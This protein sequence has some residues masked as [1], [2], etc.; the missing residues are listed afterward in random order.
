MSR[1]TVQIRENLKPLLRARALNDNTSETQIINDALAEFLVKRPKPRF[2][3]LSSEKGDL[4]ERVEDVLREEF[5][6][7]R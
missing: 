5:G 1:M 3:A 7:T 4:S 2:G 6:K